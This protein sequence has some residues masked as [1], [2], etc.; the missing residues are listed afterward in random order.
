[1]SKIK[2]RAVGK[3]GPPLTKFCSD[4]VELILA[5]IEQH[6]PYEIACSACGVS[7][8]LFYQWRKQGE[9]DMLEGKDTEY[10]ELL[11]ALNQIEAKTIK[12]N[13]A[14][15]V[16]SPDGHKGSQWLLGRRHWK[17]FGDKSAEMQLGEMLEEAIRN[18][19]S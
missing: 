7:S 16:D 5:E 10:T 19:R 8:T 13:V 1:M 18:R 14:N 15:I 12:K 17:Y 9:L 4:R 3:V 11:K 6:V 2:S